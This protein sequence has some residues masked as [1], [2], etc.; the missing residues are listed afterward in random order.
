MSEKNAHPPHWTK[1][2]PLLPIYS[3]PAPCQ[4]YQVCETKCQ[5]LPLPCTCK[6][7]INYPQHVKICN[8]LRLIF[9]IPKFNCFYNFYKK[10]V[11]VRHD[12]MQCL[13]KHKC[14]SMRYQ[15]IVAL[16]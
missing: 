9:Y 16:I 7:K 15:Q 6:K 11:T 3:D 2:N 4:K 12:K 13:K 8:S 1:N 5:P 10:Y 14:V